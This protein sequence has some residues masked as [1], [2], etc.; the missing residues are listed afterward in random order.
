VDLKFV[1]E[2]LMEN[3]HDLYSI[4]KELIEELEDN[5]EEILEGDGEQNIHEYV[6]SNISVYTYD[7]IMI[8]ANNSDLWH[9]TSGLGGETIQEQ[10]VDVI[11]EHL[12][13]VAHVWLHEQQE[14]L[15]KVAE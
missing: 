13:G 11:Y 2:K 3:K 4:E 12:S 5:K 8:Y 1:K 6:D 15:K 7:Q 10:I 9:M 14:E